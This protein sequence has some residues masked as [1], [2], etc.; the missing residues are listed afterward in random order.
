MGTATAV[1]RSVGARYFIDDYIQR[2][3]VAYDVMGGEHEGVTISAEFYKMT[4]NARTCHQ[5]ERGS[6]VRV[7]QLLIAL[8]GARPGDGKIRKTVVECAYRRDEH[9]LACGAEGCA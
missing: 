7:Q 9:F 4:A 3:A 5:I 6:R 2:P 8:S 1:G